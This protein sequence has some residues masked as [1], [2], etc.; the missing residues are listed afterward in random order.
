MN[1]TFKMKLK[2]TQY[3][4]L[5]N[6]V[7][8][9]ISQ[10][11]WAIRRNSNCSKAGNGMQNSAQWCSEPVKPRV[12]C[13][14]FVWKKLRFIVTQEQNVGA[15]HHWALIEHSLGLSLFSFRVDFYGL[16]KRM[17]SLTTKGIFHFCLI[18]W[19]RCSHKVNGLRGS[20]R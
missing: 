18:Y 2:F 4:S 6:I 7:T 12:P 5:I 13:L 19:Y 3:K 20:K 10:Q 1:V 11:T 9:N 17:R 14:W 15:R 16:D 8:N